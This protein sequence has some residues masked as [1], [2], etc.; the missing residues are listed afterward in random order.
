MLL[1]LLLLS[2]IMS[3]SMIKRIDKIPKDERTDVDFKEADNAWF[4]FSVSIILVLIFSII[5]VYEWCSIASGRTIDEKIALYQEENEKIEN[6][7]DILVKEYMDYEK[8]IFID[9]KSETSIELVSLFP[10]LKAD[11]FVSS[12]ISL[13]ET[14]SKEIRRLKEEKIELS[15]KRWLLYFGY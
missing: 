14:N 6:K 5:S 9:M 15:H 11:E 10:E 2:L 8:N 3:F 1:F 13:Y 4:C 12:Q 7:I